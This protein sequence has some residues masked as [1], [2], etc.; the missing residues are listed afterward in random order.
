[1]IPK[2]SRRRSG[3]VR[4]I[5][6]HVRRRRVLMLR[7]S[8]LEGLVLEL[9]LALAWARDQVQDVVLGWARDQVQ[10]VVL[11]WAR[12]Q[13]QVAVLVGAVRDQALVAALGAARHMVLV[14]ALGAA[15]HHVRVAVDLAP[16][17]MRMP[18][19]Y[20]VECRGRKRG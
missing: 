18:L 5:K 16:A 14:A 4:F 9:G 13:V 7:E 10:D 15:R 6:R 12:D 17:L 2:R 19:R 8:V 11:G 20:V 1:M 3:S